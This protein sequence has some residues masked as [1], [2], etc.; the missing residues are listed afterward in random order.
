MII[1]CF[2]S[3]GGG[4]WKKIHGVQFF[5]GLVETR[6]SSLIFFFIK[7]IMLRRPLL[8]FTFYYSQNKSGVPYTF[9]SN[10]QRDLGKSLQGLQFFSPPLKIRSTYRKFINRHKII[11][12]RDF[13]ARNSFFSKIVFM[14]RKKW[15]YLNW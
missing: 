11:I 13:Q 1:R 6:E 14:K 10:D 2:L 9:P 15:G 5:P 8:D 7:F 3:W 12:E 4:S